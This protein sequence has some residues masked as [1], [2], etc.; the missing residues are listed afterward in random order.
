MFYWHLHLW[1]DYVKKTKNLENTKKKTIFQDSCK[2]KNP[3]NLEKTKKTKKIKKTNI[4]GLLQIFQ[5]SCKSKNAKIQKTSRKPKKPK[6]TIF[7]KSGDRVNRQESWNIGFFDSFCFFW[8]SRGF[9]DFCIFTFA[10]VLEY[11][12]F[13][14]FCFFG[15]LEVFW[16]FAFARVLEYCVFF[17]ILV[18]SRFFKLFFVFF[19][20]F[21]ARNLGQGLVP[22]EAL[23]WIA[24]GMT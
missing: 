15:F 7:Q 8:F 22:S 23:K 12:F 18:F 19:K 13:C 4:P 14:F 11:C 9:L 17:C 21:G 10:R 6:K 16:I 24:F 3:K 5:D 2:S 20:L 1:F